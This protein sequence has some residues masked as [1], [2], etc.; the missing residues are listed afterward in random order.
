MLRIIYIL[1]RAASALTH[2]VLLRLTPAGQLVAAGIGVTAAF[3][4]NTHLNMAHQAFGFLVAAAVAALVVGRYTQLP[5]RMHR[6]A[7][8]YGTVGEPLSYRLRVANTTGKPLHDMIVQERLVDPRPVWTEFRSPVPGEHSR[9]FMERWSGFYRWRRLVVRH[10]QAYTEP[11]PLPV[12]APYAE[13]DI[14]VTVVPEKRGRL[15]LTGPMVRRPEPLGLFHALKTTDAYDSVLVLP[16]LYRL[17]PSALP[18]HRQYQPG[19]VALAASVGDS[20]EFVS[21]RDYRPGDPKR[22]I[23]WKSWAKTGKPII[24]ET[25]EEFFVRHALVLDTFAEGGDAAVFE[26]AVS[27]AASFVS[28]RSSETLLDLMFVGPEAYCFTSGRGLAQAD[29]MLE[30]LAG[31]T[32]CTDKSF[33]VIRPLVI[34]RAGLL[35]ACICV[36]QAWDADRR[37]LVETLCGLD[38]PVMVFVI[39]APG[40]SM[41]Y[42][43]GPMQ[44]NPQHFHVLEAGRMQEGLAQR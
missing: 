28:A 22:S 17:P 35:S 26:E 5:L 34:G 42:D 18:G 1:H 24:K 15:D 9:G 10:R 12:L 19:G 41:A 40:Q 44:G 23:H 30:I 8:R 21:L 25:Q 27:L 11:T 38:I 31:V 36:L 6:R 39:V 3:G 14:Q 7:P 37:S 13:N 43:P 33:D 2:W 29:R 16:R 4:I 32:L 20:E